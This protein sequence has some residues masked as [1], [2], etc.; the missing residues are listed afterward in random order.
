MEGP[1]APR[2]YELKPARS[3]FSKQSLA[4]QHTYRSSEVVGRFQRSLR[5]DAAGS[6][7]SRFF[8]DPMCAL[9]LESIRLGAT[10]RKLVSRDEGDCSG[11][12]REIQPLS[13]TP[14]IACVVLRLQL[15][16]RHSL[17][18]DVFRFLSFFAL[19]TDVA[20]AEHNRLSE[21]LDSHRALFNRYYAPE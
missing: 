2:T 10:D 16:C 18:G 11:Y 5:V 7:I 14:Q 17:V 12:V 19:D 3:A 8:G 1:C 4:C 6:V 9:F 21:F 15:P 13:A 20:P